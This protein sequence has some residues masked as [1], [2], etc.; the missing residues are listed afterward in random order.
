MLPAGGLALRGRLWPGGAAPVLPDGVAVVDAAGR[1]AG[2]GAAGDV[3]VPPGTPTR[4]VAWVGPGLVDAHVHLAFADPADVLAAGVLACRD[5]GAPPPSAARWRLLD[6]PRVAVAG[7][8]LTAPGGYPSRSWGADGFAA[9]LPADPDAAAQLVA[10]LA[11]QVDVVKLALEPRGGPVPP[12]A[13]A[14]AVVAAAHAAGRRV[15]AHALE[16]AMVAR[17]LDAGV[18]ELA[19]TPTEPLPP[20]LVERVAAAGV[21][22]VSTL[23]TFLVGGDGDG[24][25]ANAAALVAA[26]VQLRYGTDLGNAGVLPG[27]DPVELALL[28][29]AGLGPLGALR[30]ATRP[31]RDGASAGL[32]ALDA[33]P[34]AESAALTHPGLVVCGRRTLE[35]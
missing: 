5:L 10:G 9:F 4:T 31:L 17:A 26:G 18:D 21:R 8:L 6:A 25:R 11:P 19:H 32:L 22:V 27:A 28:A 33:D 7:P 13:V 15:V 34:L 16:V 2:F 35:R 24:A 30:A 3:D 14:A 23:H 29:D 1:V 20:T 12:A